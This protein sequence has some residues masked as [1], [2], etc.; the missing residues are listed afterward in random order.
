MSERYTIIFHG[1]DKDEYGLPRPF[2]RYE[3][4]ISKWGKNSSVLT[5]VP[6]SDGAK[7]LARPH[8][9]VDA[10]GAGGAY[11][12][13]RQLLSEQHPGLEVADDPDRPRAPGNR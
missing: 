10:G 5:V 9:I 1:E 2:I 4:L 3:I 12:A 13:A 11:E 6:S 8:R 7:E